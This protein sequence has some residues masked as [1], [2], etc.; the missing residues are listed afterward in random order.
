MQN[1][2]NQRLH[3]LQR[4]DRHTYDAVLWLDENRHLFKEHVFEPI[5]LSVS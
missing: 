1:V 5:L 3:L 2:R 4:V